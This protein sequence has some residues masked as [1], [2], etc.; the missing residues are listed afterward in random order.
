MSSHDAS[1]LTPTLAISSHPAAKVVL[2]VNS[3]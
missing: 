3:A 1:A 2:A